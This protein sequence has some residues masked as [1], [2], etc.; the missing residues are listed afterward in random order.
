MTALI[1]FECFPLL[2]L[3]SDTF[4]TL[5]HF[6]PMLLCSLELLFR[7]FSVTTDGSLTT[8]APVPS[9]SLVFIFVCLAPTPPLRT[10]KL[11]ALFALSIMSFALSFF[12][13]VFLPPTGL[14][15]SA[16]PHTSL[17]FCLPKLLG[18][19]LLTLPY[20]AKSHPMLTFVSSVASVA[21]TCWPPHL[22][23]LL[24][25]RPF[26]SS[27]VTRPTIKDT[28]V[29]MLL[30]TASSSLAM[31]SSMRPHSL[32]LQQIHLVLPKS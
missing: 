21:P 4:P 32:S 8:P 11:N 31:L 26:V 18:F 6:S 2:K 24:L 19:L 10:G 23:S 22:T 12:R 27:L 5:S 16:P 17:I 28:G 1:F 25:D 3:K 15:L 20:L 29:L 14:K 9:S 7:V 13:P 30:L